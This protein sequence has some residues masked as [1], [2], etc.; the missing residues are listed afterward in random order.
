M[1]NSHSELQIRYQNALSGLVEQLR[2]DRT[3]LAAIL[4]GSLANDEVWEKSDIDL[5]LV[6]SEDL[7]EGKH[8]DLVADGI[9]V[10]AILQP[11]LKFK[12]LMQRSLGSSFFH[13]MLSKSTLLYSLDDS[14]AELYENIHLQ[15]ARDREIQL[16]QFATTALPTLT[17]AQKW[18]RVKSDLHYSFLWI[19]KTIEALAKI[20]V[21]QH[22]E[23][24]GREVVLQALAHNPA[25][26]GQ[27][28][29]E[30]IEQPKTPEAIAAA[31]A[32]IDAYLHKN[33]NIFQ[34]ILDFLREANG[35]RSSTEI[36]HYFQKQ[37]GVESATAACEW[38]AD[39]GVIERLSSPT[40]L[41][42]KSRVDVEE[43][44]YYYGEESV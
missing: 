35:P 38:L 29:C 21:V 11:R 2:L 22:G 28:Y 24:V 17:K 3:V 5:L 34:P 27:L 19:M 13:S 39:S 31:L 1:A 26:F 44:A 25:V 23:I 20:E 42:P 37:M 36:D 32:A 15:G 4:C 8:L 43:A 41:T 33:L 12:A 16:L 6:C 7:K 18:Y 10:H 9:V 30:L 40:R 14:I